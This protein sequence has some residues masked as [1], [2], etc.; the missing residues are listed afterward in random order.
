ML[1]KLKRTQLLNI[2][3]EQL[4]NNDDKEKNPDDNEN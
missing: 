3:A 4:E 1:M 2:D